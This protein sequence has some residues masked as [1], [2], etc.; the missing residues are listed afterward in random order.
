MRFRSQK[1]ADEYAKRPRRR[2]EVLKNEGGRWYWRRFAGNSEITC[3]AQG[4]SSK[5][6]A[7]RAAHKHAA[8]LIDPPPI[9]VVD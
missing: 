1:K 6:A 7:K 5:A 4:Y 9:V 3:H 2:I 8:E